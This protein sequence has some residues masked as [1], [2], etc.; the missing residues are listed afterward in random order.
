M[1]LD[2]LDYSQVCDRYT[3]ESYWF[4]CMKKASDRWAERWAR[5]KEPRNTFTCY[6]SPGPVRFEVLHPQTRAVIATATVDPVSSPMTPSEVCDYVE[7]YMCAELRGLEEPRCHCCAEP[8]FLRANWDLIGPKVV[9]HDETQ[10]TVI[11]RWVPC[12][13]RH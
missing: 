1:N 12:C 10:W 11:C 7:D 2:Y 13:A 4:Q 9:K 5:R 6:A 3:M 8:A